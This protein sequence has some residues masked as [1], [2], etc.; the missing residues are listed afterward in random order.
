M[1][2]SNLSIKSLVMSMIVPISMAVLF[3]SIGINFLIY[4]KDSASEKFKRSPVETFTM[5]LFA[6]GIYLVIV[7]RIGIYPKSDWARLV[8]YLGLLIFP[9]SCIFNIVGRFYLGS[10]WSNQV[11][12]KKDHNLVQTGPYAIVRHP[13]Y[14]S[15]VWMIYAAGMIYSNYATLILNTMVFIPLMAFRAKQEEAFLKTKFSE[16]DNYMTSTGLFFPK[17]WRSNESN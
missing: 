8:T 9:S 12:L 11:R 5:T 3:I 6:L 13:L 1:M 17:L 7:N 4:D 2:I 15:T 16:Y 10:N 14:A